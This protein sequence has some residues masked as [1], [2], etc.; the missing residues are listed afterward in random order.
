MFRFR[1]AKQG[2]FPET[3]AG[4]QSRWSSNFRLTGSIDVYE[5]IQ[6]GGFRMGF[7]DLF[8]PKVAHSDPKVRKKA[9]M[10]EKDKQLL[11]KVIENDNDDRVREAARMR[12]EDLT[13]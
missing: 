10:K 3:G 4:L 12:L 13:A 11:K 9:V 1:W 7:R 6:K 2:N 8:L 5:Y